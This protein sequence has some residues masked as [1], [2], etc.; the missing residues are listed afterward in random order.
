MRYMREFP[1][2]WIA[3]M[4]YLHAAAYLVAALTVVTIPRAWAQSPVGQGTPFP[5]S[6]G[7]AQLVGHYPGGNTLRVVVGLKTP[8]PAEE[9]QFLKDLQTKGSP[10]FHQY[11]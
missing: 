11:L 6:H 4:R 10:A 9:E 3:R 7:K 1:V 8:H 5:V 2:L